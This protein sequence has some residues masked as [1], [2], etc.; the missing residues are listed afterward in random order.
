MVLPAEFL[1]CDTHGL[2]GEHSAVQAGTIMRQSTV[3]NM[4]ATTTTEAFCARL[5]CVDFGVLNQ[6]TPPDAFFCLS[7]G[8]RRAVADLREAQKSGLSV[9]PPGLRCPTCT[10]NRTA[11]I[12]LLNQV[13]P[14]LSKGPPKAIVVLEQDAKP[15]P[16]DVW[17]VL[18][19]ALPPQARSV[20]TLPKRT[21]LQ[22]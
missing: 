16:V 5:L 12:L 19:S 6:D 4:A 8:R 10:A 21:T 11:V 2:K 20:P 15:V 22:P 14:R 7:E 1:R 3:T 13:H 9:K 18:L 17:Q